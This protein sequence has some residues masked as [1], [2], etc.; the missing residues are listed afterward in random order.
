MPDDQFGGARWIDF[1]V[2]A[3]ASGSDTIDILPRPNADP[4]GGAVTV[5]EIFAV[6]GLLVR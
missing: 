2:P 1:V 4:T 5:L 3:V 6:L